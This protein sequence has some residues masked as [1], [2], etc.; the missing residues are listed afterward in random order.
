[1]NQIQLACQLDQLIQAG[2]TVFVKMEPEILDFTQNDFSFKLIFLSKLNECEIKIND[3]NLMENLA[4]VKTALLENKKLSVIGW[5]LKN[6]FT[7]VLSKTGGELEFESK[8]LDLRLAECFIGVREKAPGKFVEVT[9]RLKRLLAD[10]SWEKF[11]SIYQKVYLPLLSRVIPKIEIEGV[12]NTA[13]RQIL[14]SYYEIEGQVGGRLACQLAYKNCFNPHSLSAEEKLELQPKGNNL[15]FLCFDYHFHEVCIL[16]WLSQDEVLGKLISED[17][18]F[19]KKLYTQITGGECNS[20]IKRSFC[21]DYLFLPVIYGQSAKTLAERAN[22]SVA[23]AEKLIFRL[24]SIF[25]R[26]FTWVENHTGENNV[27]VDYIGRKRKFLDGE[28]YK[29]RNFII[30]SPGAIFCLE[31]L[32]YLHNALRDYGRVV[33]HIHDGYI[34]RSS[35]EQVEMVRSRCLQVLEGESILFPGLKL[36]TN[37]KISKTLA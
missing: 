26:L 15:V 32:V 3:E 5:N 19:Y 23:T 31:K 36:R 22:T 24:K 6:L 33:A 21:K 28:E 17:G 13:K 1:M 18:D 34:V 2:P 12:F 8:L 16:A 10:S 9:F 4:L 25:S 29:Y 14:F 7:Y 27:Y 35:E 30:Q 37:C 11:K 20:D